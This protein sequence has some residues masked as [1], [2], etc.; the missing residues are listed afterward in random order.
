MLRNALYNKILGFCL[1]FYGF[2]FVLRTRN[3]F[4]LRKNRFAC[5]ATN[6][7]TQILAMT[8]HLPNPL[9]NG[10]GLLLPNIDYKT[11]SAEDEK[12]KDILNSNK[13]ERNT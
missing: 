2:Y 8:T 6:L 3:T 7:L 1:N 5:A 4:L 11:Q 9:R 10:R 12:L 13:C